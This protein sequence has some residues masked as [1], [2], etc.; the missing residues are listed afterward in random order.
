MKNFAFNRSKL[1]IPI[2]INAVIFT[3]LSILHFY[4]ALGGKLWYNSVLPTSSNGM[5]KLNP[6][7][8]AGLIVA[9]VLLFLGLTTL[10][11]IGLFDRF[12]ERKYFRY[13]TLIIALIFFLRAIGDFKFIGFFK[14]VKLTT[15][16]INDTRIFSPL[17]LVLAIISLVIFLLS[18]NV[19]KTT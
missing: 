12:I 6:S 3:L 19:K 9:F 10:G 7:I 8:T 5:H 11:N 16:G 1:I 4:W 14:T 15:F 13:G 17:C 18:E 2:I